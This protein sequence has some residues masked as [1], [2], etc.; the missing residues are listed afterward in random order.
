MINNV[1]TKHN[2]LTMYGNRYITE[3]NHVIYS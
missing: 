1:K 3:D 2:Q